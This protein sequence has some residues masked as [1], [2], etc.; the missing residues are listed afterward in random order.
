[1]SCMEAVVVTASTAVSVVAAAVTEASCCK[2]SCAK[3]FQFIIVKNSSCLL[4]LE[5]TL[6][7]PIS[8]RIQ[9]TMVESVSRC[10]AISAA[11]NVV[12][13]SFS[14][15]LFFSFSPHSCLS[16]SLY[17]FFLHRNYLSLSSVMYFHLASF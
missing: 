4:H 12:T 16:F 7:F 15:F 1:M 3:V 6:S 2:K 5:S 13:P 8:A 9:L 10:N 11:G 17:L 14:C